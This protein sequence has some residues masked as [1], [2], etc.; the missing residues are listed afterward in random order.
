[1]SN[2]TPAL[3]SVPRWQRCF[4]LASRRCRWRSNWIDVAVRRAI[5]VQRSAGVT[6]VNCAYAPPLRVLS[7]P[8]SPEMVV[9]DWHQQCEW[10]LHQTVCVLQ[11]CHG[12]AVLMGHPCAKPVAHGSE[13]SRAIYFP[14]LALLS[15]LY[16]AEYRPAGQAN[17][18]DRCR[19]FI[20]ICRVIMAVVTA[21]IIVADANVPSFD[22]SE[23]R[24][25]VPP[26]AR[27]RH[28]YVAIDC[29]CGFFPG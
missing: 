15:P 8:V 28:R 10:F 18:R 14:V 19:H 23:F 21:V 11:V 13:R 4:Y 1:M 7:S 9:T 25:S 12:V 6:S 5:D 29:Q 2:I 3:P 17:Q 16:S 22:H 24:L 26:I 27:C 20:V